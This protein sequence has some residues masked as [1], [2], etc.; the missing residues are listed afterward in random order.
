M[1]LLVCYKKNIGNFFCCV[2][3]VMEERSW[4]RSRIHYSEV[5]IRIRTKMS[6]IPNTARYPGTG[7]CWQRLK[8]INHFFNYYKPLMW[9]V[10]KA[11]D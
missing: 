9:A 2:L 1:C 11:A 6:R 3:K 4:I 7:I 8:I 10:L 5:G